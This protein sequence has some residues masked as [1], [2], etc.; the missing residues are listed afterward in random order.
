MTAWILVHFECG[1]GFFCSFTLA[2]GFRIENHRMRKM[3]FSHTWVVLETS[4]RCFSV[5]SECGISTA[6][7]PSVKNVHRVNPEVARASRVAPYI[8]TSA[9]MRSNRRCRNRRFQ[10]SKACDRA[11]QLL[12]VDF[13]T[14]KKRNIRCCGRRGVALR[15]R[16]TN[17]ADVVFQHSKRAS[18]SRAVAWSATTVHFRN[19]R[20]KV[21][22]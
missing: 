12:A 10:H 21:P 17:A 3:S 7:V 2:F 22:P 19:E 9:R 6:C 18:R 15:V 20:K 4:S 8:A 11:N 16:K 5:R 14:C 13:S 1:N